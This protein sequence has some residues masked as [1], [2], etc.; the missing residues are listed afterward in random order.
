MLEIP[1]FFLILRFYTIYG[2]LK[3]NLFTG[4]CKWLFVFLCGPVMNWSLVQAVTQAVRLY[5]FIHVF[6]GSI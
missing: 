6:M 4:E 1:S 5:T 2:S 3:R